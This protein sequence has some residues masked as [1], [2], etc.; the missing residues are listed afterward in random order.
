MSPVANS[1]YSTIDGRQSAR[2]NWL[3][4][5]VRLPVGDDWAAWRDPVMRRLEY[6]LKLPHGWDGYSATPVRLEVVHFTLQMLRSICPPDTP[7][8]Q[9]VPGT[10]GDLQVEWHAPTTTIELHVKAP[11]AVSAWRESDSVPDGEEVNL[12]NDF[13]VVLRWIQEML[14]DESAAVATAA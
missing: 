1:A 3:T 12:T 8:P 10:G 6:L 9:I 11:N 14:E 5:P 7:A 4:E 13:L 2:P